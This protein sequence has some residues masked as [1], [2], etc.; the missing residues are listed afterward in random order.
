[1]PIVMPL[2]KN[3][4][5]KMRKSN[6]TLLLTIIILFAACGIKSASSRRV[7]KHT[8]SYYRGDGK[9]LL[10]IKP[11]SFYAEKEHLEADFTYNKGDSTK[12]FV[13]INISVYGTP[14]FPK[15]DSAI[16]FFGSQSYT[17]T[18]VNLLYKDNLNRHPFSRQSIEL[19]V[20]YFEAFVKNDPVSIILYHGAEKKNYVSGKTW[21]KIHT[22]LYQMIFW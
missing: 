8:E 11:I 14:P 7:K 21:R 16:L 6:F 18:D 4:T 5:A 15:I 20:K 2:L 22:K 13:V 17:D 12:K 1:M 19:P 10:F 3:L 9:N